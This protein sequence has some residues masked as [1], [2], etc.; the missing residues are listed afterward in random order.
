MQAS[1]RSQPF[2]S[3]RPRHQAARRPLVAAAVVTAPPAARRANA[4]AAAPRRAEAAAAAPAQAA[5]AGAASA[6]AAALAAFAL[7]L[8]PLAAPPPAAAKPNAALDVPA[9]SDF[10]ASP[11]S[12]VRFCE[13]KE[14]SGP[15]PEAGDLVVVDYTARALAAG[16]GGDAACAAVIC[17][18]GAAQRMRVRAAGGNRADTLP[19]FAPNQPETVHTN[20]TGG[21]VFDGSQGFKFFVGEKDLTIPGGG[22]DLAL[23]GDGGA[24]PVRTAFEIDVI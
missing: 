4:A 22:F 19:A 8:S 6:A 7:A 2:G 15:P 12:G 10:K 20:T 9:C 24:M 1:L 21:R 3:T 17:V 23:L 18:L 14:G 11:A 16:A 5:Q 13:V